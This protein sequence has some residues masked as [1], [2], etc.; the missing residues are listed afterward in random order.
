MI[1]DK[2]YTDLYATMESISL[3]SLHPIS[4]II[5]GTGSSRYEKLQELNSTEIHHTFQALGSRRVVHFSSLSA[6]QEVD[7]NSSVQELLSPIPH[8]ILTCMRTKQTRSAPQSPSH[9]IRRTSTPP[10][11]AKADTPTSTPARYS[12]SL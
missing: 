5:V 3:A 1:V 6:D 7:I 4:I 10:P 11:F 12:E 9:A 2:D 8:E